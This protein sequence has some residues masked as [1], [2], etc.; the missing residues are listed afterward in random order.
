MPPPFPCKKEACV[1]PLAEY[2]YCVLMSR[3]INNGK[4]NGRECPQ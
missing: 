1:S 2:P 3:I 4:K